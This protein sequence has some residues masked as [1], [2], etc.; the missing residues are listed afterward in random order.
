M[1]EDLGKILKESKVWD[2]SEITRL[3]TKLLKQ[4]GMFDKKYNK[5]K[6]SFLIK[7]LYESYGRIALVET[8]EYYFRIYPNP[9]WDHFAKHVDS[10]YKA[11]QI[12]KED[13]KLREVLREQ[14]KEWLKD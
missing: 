2:T 4:R 11:L 6:A 3:F 12:K 14:A 8:V 5:H 7:E 1:S 9:S 10:F 13:D